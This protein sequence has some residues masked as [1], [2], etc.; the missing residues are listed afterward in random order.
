MQIKQDEL[1]IKLTNIR[2]LLDKHKVEGVL[3]R[4]GSSFAWGTCGAASYTNTATTEGAAS[5]FVTRDH[6]YLLTNNIEAPRLQQ[7]DGLVDQGW[8][9]LVSPWT[10]SQKEMNRL[11]AGK[12]FIA[13]VAFQDAKDVSAEISRL[14]SNLTEM[15]RT[16]FRQL[17]RL[18]ADAMEAAL[19]SLKPGMSE[20]EIAALLGLETQ[21]RGVQPIVNLIAVDDRVYSYRHPLPTSKE[22]DKYAML[23]LCGRKWGLVC[24]ITRLIHFGPIPTDLK[25]KILATAYISA[26]LIKNTRPGRSLDELFTIGQRAYALQGVPNEWKHHHQGGAVG[27]EPR[28]SLGLPDSQDVVMA[29]QAYAWN[30]SI[31][32]AKVEDTILVEE[33]KNEIITL[34]PALPVTHIKGV[35]CSLAL[36][37]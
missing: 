3:L 36:E 31:S 34:T 21:Q 19:G 4:R 32:G 25:D 28:E 2:I 29:G 5:L 27:Y 14:R 18:C 33:D 24:S 10:E 37:M 8:E 20:Y 6:H 12:K 23:V 35:P 30:P 9:W 22:L 11:I 13:D 7:E 16:R 17:G 26:T 15:E 1:E